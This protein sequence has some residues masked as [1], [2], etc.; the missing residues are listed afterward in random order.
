MV[1]LYRV[2][3]VQPTTN[4]LRPSAVGGKIREYW[5][6]AVMELWDF[7]GGNADPINKN[8]CPVG[9]GFADAT[10]WDWTKYWKVLY[11]E[12]EKPSATVLPFTVRK[13]RPAYMGLQGTQFRAVVGD[14]IKVHFKNMLPCRDPLDPV[15]PTYC[16][17][18][19]SIHPHGV[20][21][22]KDS[23]G[24]P[25]ADPSYSPTAADPKLDDFVYP[26]DEV[27]Y[28]WG[29]LPSSGP[30]PKDASTVTWFYH[31]HTDEIG[32]YSCFSSGCRCYAA[33]APPSAAPSP[34][35]I[36]L[37]IPRFPFVL[38]LFLQASHIQA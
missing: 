36:S 1:A 11:V 31:S 5:V 9:A 35:L 28:N 24:A 27:E 26:G 34:D 6:G 7:A 29:V 17:P 23:E 20:A 10:Q 18:P 8:N 25:Y 13:P 38:S 21:Y 30:G 4:F 2:K 37:T 15:D 3:G 12:F 33:N 22:M 16:H 19:V 32:K 14:T